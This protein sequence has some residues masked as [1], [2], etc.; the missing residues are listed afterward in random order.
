[1]G[2]L[3]ALSQLSTDQSKL[4]TD[5]AALAADQANVATDTTAVSSDDAAIVAALTA[6]PNPAYTGPDASGNV[7]VY[8]LD[9]TQ[10]AGYST[11]VVSPAT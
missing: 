2:L 6:G 11:T 9:S 4:S 10:A 5:Q 3:A 1:M 7:T 8:A